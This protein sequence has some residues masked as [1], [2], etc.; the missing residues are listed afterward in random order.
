MKM[1]SHMLDVAFVVES[2][3]E[4]QTKIPYKDLLSSLRRRL[5]SLG[6]SDQPE[7]FGHIDT[8][9]F[10]DHQLPSDAGDAAAATVPAGGAS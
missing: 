6:S 10:D 4:D 2:K 9:E 5:I 3:Y 1:Y 7:A 8:Y